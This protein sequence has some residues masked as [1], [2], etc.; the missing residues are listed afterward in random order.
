VYEAASEEHADFIRA[1]SNNGEVA[2]L[3]PP[4]LETRGPFVV[5]DW[6]VAW[7]NKRAD[8]ECL[9]N[10]LLRLHAVNPGGLPKPGFDYWQEILVPR[11][12]RAAA[13]LHAERLARAVVAEVSVAMENCPSTL[14]HP[15]VTPDNVLSDGPGRWKIVDN[16]LLTSG[17]IPLLDV[18]N[19][20]HALGAGRGDRLAQAWLRGAKHHPGIPFKNVRMAWLVRRT[21]S[22]YVAGR[23]DEVAHY[24]HCFHVGDWHLPF[25]V[26][27]V[28]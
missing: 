15:D 14:V 1:V 16:E 10:I 26:G 12:L 4:V 2:D 18:C 25:R 9:S 19:A 17:R 13:L 23:F 22:A 20:A 8:P 11:F 7:S 21:G 5:T 3:F 24:L 27:E 28:G 6:I